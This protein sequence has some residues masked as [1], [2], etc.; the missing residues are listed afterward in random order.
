MGYII[1]FGIIEVYYYVRIS[2]VY[3]FIFLE[4]VLHSS[5]VYIFKVFEFA[6]VI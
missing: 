3:I 6:Q 2:S 4:P 5:Y 1:K